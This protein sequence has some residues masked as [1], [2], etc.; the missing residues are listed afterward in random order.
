MV[1][2]AC[3][4]ET[5]WKD[6]EYGGPQAEKIAAVS[7]SNQR[8]HN[9]ISLRLPIRVRVKSFDTRFEDV[10]STVNVSQSG[11]YFKGPSPYAS[12]LIARVCMNYSVKES[13]G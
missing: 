13:S 3:K 9:R 10:T 1:C 11:V 12:G 6:S 7:K 5:Y 2:D 8:R 4:K